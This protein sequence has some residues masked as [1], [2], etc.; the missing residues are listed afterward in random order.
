L[1][2]GNA[3]E[4]RQEGLVG[5]AQQGAAEDGIAYS[6]SYF[7]YNIFWKLQSRQVKLLAEKKAPDS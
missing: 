5:G 2:R 3:V 7:V 1:D 4:A 6:I